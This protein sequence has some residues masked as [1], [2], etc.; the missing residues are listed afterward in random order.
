MV[1]QDIRV[2]GRLLLGVHTCH[3]TIRISVSVLG[4]IALKNLIGLTTLQEIRRI[5]FEVIT[6]LYHQ[7]AI[8]I[9]TG[10]LVNGQAIGPVVVERNNKRCPTNFSNFVFSRF[11]LT[12]NLRERRLVI[13]IY[14][15]VPQYDIRIFVY[16]G[17]IRMV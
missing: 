9:H 13:R 5:G 17:I 8:L 6:L 2:G 1:L 11:L 7:L 16:K 12:D 4:G 14:I 10:A 3:D 15:V